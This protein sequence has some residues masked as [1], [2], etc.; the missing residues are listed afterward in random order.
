MTDLIAFS[1]ST[2][3][4]AL[5]LLVPGQAQKE[6]FVNQALAIL[7][8]L[9]PGTVVASQAQ[10]PVNAAQGSC[11]RITAT[12]SQAWAGREDHLAISIA[13]DWHFIAPRAGMRVF[14]QGA[15]H[16]L[17]FQ[18]GWLYAPAPGLA[19]GGATIDVEARAAIGQLI[20]SL[21]N[22]GVLAPPAG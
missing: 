15:G 20:Q 14:D 6:F 3:N 16:A 11:F 17:L 9:Q 4:A 22:I 18:S 13:G 2:S 7:D 1:S 21:R 5:P 8:A 10:P 19:S 12:A